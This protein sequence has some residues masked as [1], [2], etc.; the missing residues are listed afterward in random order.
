M[1]GPYSLTEVHIKDIVKRQAGVY[2]LV[3]IY[4]NAIYVGRADLDLNDRLKDHLSQS[5]VNVCIKRSGVNAFYLE[6]AQSPEGA[7]NLEC[8]WYHRYRP[9]CNVAHPAKNSLSW[10]C[11]ICGL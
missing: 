4:N 2:I 1:E 10:S 8:N 5:E 11:P 6:Y 7:Y 9:T 3:N